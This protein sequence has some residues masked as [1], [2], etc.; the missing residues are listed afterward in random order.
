MKPLEND[1]IYCNDLCYTH[2]CQSRLTGIILVIPSL[3]I[4][5]IIRLIFQ[6]VHCFGFWSDT[7]K[8]N[9]VTCLYRGMHLVLLLP[10]C[11]RRC[12]GG[13]LYDC[14]AVIRHAELASSLGVQRGERRR[15]RPSV[16]PIGPPRE[17]QVQGLVQGQ[18]GHNPLTSHL[19]KQSQ[20]GR[21]KPRGASEG[22][23]GFH[24]STHTVKCSDR[25]SHLQ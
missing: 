10:T 8:T 19:H 17:L 22:R 1:W 2:S 9:V 14:G 25:F 7:C 4:R 21:V 11:V 16:P 23:L 6:S 5:C 15:A 13:G 3:F 18:H 24:A 12:W 20:R